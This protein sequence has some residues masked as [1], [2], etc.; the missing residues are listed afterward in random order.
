MKKF[1]SLLL[2]FF[3]SCSVAYGQPKPRSPIFGKL[4]YNKSLQKEMKLTAFQIKKMRQIYLN[5]IPIGSALTN[6]L[7]IKE[8][9]YSRT[10]KG[11]ILKIRNET[12]GKI[13]TLLK[14]KVY[15]REELLNRSKKINTVYEEEGKLLIKI[16]TKKQLSTFNRLRGRNTR[17]DV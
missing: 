2:L 6:S 16:L 10:Q 12:L 15:S 14:Q 8:L 11:K 4:L 17:P 1:V 9:N 7:V 13:R 3:V 5:S